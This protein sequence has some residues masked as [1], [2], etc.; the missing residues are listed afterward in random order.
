MTD[1]ATPSTAPVATAAHCTEEHLGDLQAVFEVIRQWPGIR[2]PKPGVFYIKA[3]PF[4]NFW[5]GAAGRWANARRGRGWGQPIVLPG[6]ISELE[7][8]QFLREVKDR[9]CRTS[10]ALSRRVVA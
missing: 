8:K 10:L 5:R 3:S 1:I 4:M 2:E 6:P 7:R 9:Y